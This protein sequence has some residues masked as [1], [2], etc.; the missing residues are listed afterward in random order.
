MFVILTLGSGLPKIPF[1]WKCG[2]LFYERESCQKLNWSF[3]LLF[4]SPS[5]PLQKRDSELEIQ[6][7]EVIR[8]FLKGSAFSVRNTQGYQCNWPPRGWS[9]QTGTSHT[10]DLPAAARAQGCAAKVQ[11]CAFVTEGT[12]KLSSWRRKKKG[13]REQISL[14]TKRPSW[15]SE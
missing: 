10:W 6:N 4:Y 9:E 5:P 3:F 12:G 13:S 1:M 8:F 14:H 11:L 15:F 7:L 2:T